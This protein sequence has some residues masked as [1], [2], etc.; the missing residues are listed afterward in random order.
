MSRAAEPGAVHVWSIPL[1]HPAHLRVGAGRWLDAAER[2]RAARCSSGPARR[3]FVRTRGAVRTVLAAYTGLP[4]GGLEFGLGE[5]GKPR[6]VGVSSPVRFNVAH[7]GGLALLAVAWGREVGVDVEALRRDLPA[8]RLA[9]RFYPPTEQAAVCEA[10][11]SDEERLRRYVR[12]WTRKEAY[13]KAFGG[14]LV[15]GASVPVGPLG[16]AVGLPV[17]GALGLCSISDLP[18]RDGWLASVAMTGDARY[19]LS[20]RSWPQDLSALKGENRVPAVL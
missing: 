13:V 19:S 7:S 8:A 1:W 4:S 6:L 5:H 15:Q 12:L 2:S 10:G 16:R 20:L 3:E 17:S 14:R 9:A 18:F 11:L